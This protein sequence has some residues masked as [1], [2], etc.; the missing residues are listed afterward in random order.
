MKD[1]QA[2]LIFS[3]SVLELEQKLQLQHNSAVDIIT[4]E[5][6]K[7]AAAL[8]DQLRDLQTQHD[9]GIAEKDA[10]HAQLMQS[11]VSAAADEVQLLEKRFKEEQQ[12][13]EASRMAAEE[14]LATLQQEVQKLQESSSPPATTA[15]ESQQLDTNVNNVSVASAFFSGK[16][17]EQ[18]ELGILIISLSRR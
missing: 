12:A 10:Q 3:S 9:E 7:V 11:Q 2:A 14:Q 6:E 15:E 5:H 17:H 4:N 1:D 16:A 8:Y 18:F 13:L